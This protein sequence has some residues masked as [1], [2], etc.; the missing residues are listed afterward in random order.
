MSVEKDK[1]KQPVSISLWL[2]TKF[3]LG[4]NMSSEGAD[5]AGNKIAS[6]LKW[7]AILG[8]FSFLVFSSGFLI[9][10]LAPE[11]IIKPLAVQL[12][13]SPASTRTSPAK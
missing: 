6:G 3:N 2:E 13:Y 8:G 1:Q 5:K 10:R 7:L 11:G 9:G 12:P 4:G